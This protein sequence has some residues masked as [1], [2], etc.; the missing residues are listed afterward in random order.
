MGAP[1]APLT[2]VKVT[3]TNLATNVTQTA[4]TNSDGVYSLPA[5]EPGTYRLTLQKEGFKKESREPIRVESSSTVA[6]DFSLSVG[7]TS[8]EVTVTGEA[9]MVQQ[10]SST[11]QY[12]T[13]LKQIDELPILNQSALQI[14]SLLPGVQGDPG[15]EQAAITTGFT[16]PGGGLSISGSAMGTVQFQAD[17]VGNTSMYFGR[18]SLSFS[19][20]AVS[21]V[22]VVQ[23][24]YSAEYRSGGG[25]I[26]SMTTKSGSN[27]L[28][29]TVFS[30]SQNDILNAAP[31]QN[32]FRKKGMVR[33]WRGGTDFGGPVVIP[34]LYNG[35]NLTFFFFGFEPL[36][37]FTQP[38]SCARAATRQK[39]QGDFSQSVYNSATYQPVFLFQ[40]F[41]AG[42]NTPIVAPTTSASPIFPLAPVPTIPFSPPPHIT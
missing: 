18:I 10:A 40:H 20:D 23:N 9:S 34:K 29:G 32:S 28:H 38:A 26:V 37:Q 2:A 13:D 25:G 3:A 5:L 30:F 31:W 24:S 12:R 15:G 35:T 4:T 14:V 7:S 22:S 19:T 36:R 17:G 1:S 21:E 39:R 11:V 6:L 27:G 33:Y 8:T 42:T 41:L 16:T